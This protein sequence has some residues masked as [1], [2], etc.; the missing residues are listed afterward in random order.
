M[1]DLS[2]SEFLGLLGLGA[3]GA[4]TVPVGGSEPAKGSELVAS[5]YQRVPLQASE[6]DP[7]EGTIKTEVFIGGE[8]H[9]MHRTL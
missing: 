6:S 3:L 4:Q 8:W 2:R 1:R 5:G 9:L 7:A